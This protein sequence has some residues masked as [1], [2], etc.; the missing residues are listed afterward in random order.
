MNLNLI[1]RLSHPICLSY[2]MYHERIEITSSSN[3][4]Q[5]RLHT[6]YFFVYYFH[7]FQ[8]FRLIFPFFTFFV[9]SPI[10]ILI[11]EFCFCKKRRVF[12]LHSFIFDQ[13]RVSLTLF[14][15]P[16]VNQQMVAIAYFRIYILKWLKLNEKFSETETLSPTRHICSKKGS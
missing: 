2:A 16:D 5:S 4:S 9:S 15:Y 3:D 1:I 6:I 14:I 7:F 13:K 12:P 8:F 10:Q 11:C